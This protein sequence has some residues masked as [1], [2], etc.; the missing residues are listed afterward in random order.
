MTHICSLETVLQYQYLKSTKLAFIS[1]M[2][3]VVLDKNKTE[4]SKDYLFVFFREG[5]KWDEH[6]RGLGSHNGHLWQGQD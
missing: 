2:F 4:N 6:G 5:N 3:W 1:L